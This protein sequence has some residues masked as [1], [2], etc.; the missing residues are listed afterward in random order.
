MN[1][2]KEFDMRQR[3][4]VSLTFSNPKNHY[5]MIVCDDLGICA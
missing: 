5:P 1:L 2:S 4:F 3:C